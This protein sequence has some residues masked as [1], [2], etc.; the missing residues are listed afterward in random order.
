MKK[1]HK[2]KL[3]KV[4][5]SGRLKI[6]YNFIFVLGFFVFLGL[7]VS[8]PFNQAQGLVEYAQSVSCPSDAKVCPDGT[9]VSRTGLNCTFPACPGEPVS[10]TI[11]GQQV[12]AGAMCS[13]DTKFCSDG[14]TL[15][16]TG[17]NCTFPACPE[18]Q[19]GSGSV[20]SPVGS[21][22]FGLGCPADSVCNG[23]IMGQ[24]ISNSCTDPEAFNQ[25]KKGTRVNKSNSPECDS[26]KST[27]SAI[28]NLPWFVVGNDG[29]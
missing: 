23:V 17:P 21:C 3:K 6:G 15:S 25:S 20:C 27:D 1:K 4:R 22:W 26:Q 9:V 13:Q 24:C 29:C 18:T 10:P 28:P 2:H 16:R 8:Q 14:T 11:P 12:S 7:I 5:G 19:G